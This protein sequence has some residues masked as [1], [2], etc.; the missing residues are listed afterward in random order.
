V[1]E[2]YLVECRTI[3]YSSCWPDASHKNPRPPLEGEDRG[4]GGALALT[5]ALSRKRERE[6]NVFR[7][8]KPCSS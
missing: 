3:F 1:S 7:S 4:E 6:R 5:L 8:K 2:V